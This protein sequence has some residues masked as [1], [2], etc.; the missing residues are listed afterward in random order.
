M[1]REL[2]SVLNIALLPNTAEGASANKVLHQVRNTVHVHILPGS[3]HS[4][5]DAAEL[6]R[7][8]WLT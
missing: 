5:A 7:M 2:K 6:T 3:K 4:D 1:Q 8:H